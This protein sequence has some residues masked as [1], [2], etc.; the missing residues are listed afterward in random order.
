MKIQVRRFCTLSQALLCGSLLI[1]AAVKTPAARHTSG[2][3]DEIRSDDSAQANGQMHAAR[4]VEYSERDVVPVKTKIRYTTL[5]ILP[6]NEQIL[7]FTCAT[8]SS[9]S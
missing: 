9:G 1:F 8:K 7:D 4:L 2:R 5:I 3:S 6:K